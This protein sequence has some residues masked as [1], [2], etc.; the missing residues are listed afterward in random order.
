MFDSRE[1]E[2]PRLAGAP[3]DYRLPVQSNIPTNPPGFDETTGE[4]R[5]LAGP[6]GLRADGLCTDGLGA[7]GLGADAP[8]ADELDTARLDTARPDAD[9]ACAGAPGTGGREA[10]SSG[11][12]ES[13]ADESAV[14]GNA[15]LVG[16]GDEKAAAAIARTV[17]IRQQMGALQAQ[18]LHELA[19]LAVWVRAGN[20]ELYGCDTAIA[21][22][23]LV[24]DLAAAHR[25]SDR[26]MGRRLADAERFVTDYPA[27]VA[28]LNDGRIDLGHIRV[29]ADHGLPIQDDTA[30][31]VYEQA[32]LD[33]A[34]DTTPGRLGRY[35][36]RAAATCGGVTFQQRYDL[37]CCG[38]FGQRIRL[39]SYA[40]VAGFW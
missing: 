30:R 24:A 32:V 16:A 34:A 12:D 7:D 11:A 26:A 18:E 35:A 21:H 37:G 23:S 10:D 22:R 36:Q 6:D 25:V 28:A 1:N 15:V 8:C 38:D 33:K 39:N 3:A 29:I 27:A 14:V 17:A 40:A 20:T 31:S 5:A 9:G 4:D 19:T 13:S 2:E